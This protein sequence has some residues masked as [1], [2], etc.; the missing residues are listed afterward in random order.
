M[1]VLYWFL[2]M[3]CIV[4]VQPMYQPAVNDQFTGCNYGST[5][6]AIGSRFLVLKKTAPCN[7]AVKRENFNQYHFN[8]CRYTVQSQNRANERQFRANSK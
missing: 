1:L 2:I 5:K 7:R 4:Y 6:T 3:I 8:T